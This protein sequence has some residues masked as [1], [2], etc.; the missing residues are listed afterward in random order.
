MKP[1]G[2][3][4]DYWYSEASCYASCDSILLPRLC[5]PMSDLWIKTE[6]KIFQSS[7]DFH[8]FKPPQNHIYDLPESLSDCQ[9]LLILPE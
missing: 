5:S 7:H 4:T 6:N 9:Y 2:L 3:G 1:Q 8:S